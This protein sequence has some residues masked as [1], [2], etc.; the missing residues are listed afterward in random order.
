MRVIISSQIE[1]FAQKHDLLITYGGERMPS[2]YVPEGC[3]LSPWEDD[4]DDLPRCLVCGEAI[5]PDR[6]HV[7]CWGEWV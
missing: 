4:E 3:P 2:G 7:D 5:Q 6:P 1:Q